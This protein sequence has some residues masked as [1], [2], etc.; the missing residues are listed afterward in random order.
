MEGPAQMSDAIR[1]YRAVGPHGFLSNLYPCEVVV[2]GETFKSAEHAYQWYKTNKNEIAKWI[3]EAPFPRCAA[4]A[5]HGLFPYDVVKGWNG[6][7][8]QVMR[9]VLEAKFKDPELRKMLLA[10]GDAELVEGSKS[11]AFWGVGKNGR[12]RNT[13][14]RLLMEVRGQIR[15]ELRSIV[16]GTF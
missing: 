13:L 5:G 15:V 16:D 8:V 6:S 9:Q 1:F 10:T 4:I 14:G 2:D 7:K 3:R 12:G 11:D